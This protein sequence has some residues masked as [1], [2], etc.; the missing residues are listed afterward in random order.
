MAAVLEYGIW[1]GE[2]GPGAP[3][4]HRARQRSARRAFGSKWLLLSA[5]VDKS[6]S[7]RRGRH[8]RLVHATCGGGITPCFSSAWQPVGSAE[9]RRE[10]AGANTLVWREMLVGLNRDHGADVGRELFNPAEPDKAV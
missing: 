10:F 2:C 6:F 3:V 1:L 9:D 4:R 7:T 8:H 5:L